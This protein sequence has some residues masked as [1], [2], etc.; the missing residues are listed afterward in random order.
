MKR[1][2]KEQGFRGPIKN[3]SDSATAAAVKTAKDWFDNQ[4]LL[5]DPETVPYSPP[6]AAAL[7]GKLV[8][9]EYLSD[10]FDG[11]ERVYRHELDEMRD[12]A[13]SP[14][15]ATIILFPGLKITK[16]GIEG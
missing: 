13:I 7:V 16:R 14:D 6:K 4:A 9:I 11:V 1:P 5:T 2:R 10:K 8:A 12:M 15:G 3:P